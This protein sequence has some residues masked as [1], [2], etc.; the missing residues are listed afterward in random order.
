M[1]DD[2]VGKLQFYTIART[3][4]AVLRCQQADVKQQVLVAAFRKLISTPRVAPIDVIKITGNY[5]LENE[6]IAL[7][8][9]NL[10]N[11]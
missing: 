8:E 3:I 11:E 9:L 10:L 2:M 4:A 6:D 5:Q 1:T 7:L